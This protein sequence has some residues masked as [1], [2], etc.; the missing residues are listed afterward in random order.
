MRRN[1]ARTAR[2]LGGTAVN[3]RP[4]IGTL[5]SRI[6]SGSP[7]IGAPKVQ[8]NSTMRPMRPGWA[9]AVRRAR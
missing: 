6:T 4:A 8:P 1:I 9:A 7:A 3:S 2:S 5:A